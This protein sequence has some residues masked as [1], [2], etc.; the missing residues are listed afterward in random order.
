MSFRFLAGSDPTLRHNSDSLGYRMKPTD[1]AVIRF[2]QRASGSPKAVK[3]WFYPGDQYGLEFVYPKPTRDLIRGE[4]RSQ[5]PLSP[6]SP[7]AT[8]SGDPL[9]LSP[10]LSL[11]LILCQSMYADIF[12]TRLQRGNVSFWTE[13]LSQLGLAAAKAGCLVRQGNLWIRLQ[14]LYGTAA[15]SRSS[16]AVAVPATALVGERREVNLGGTSRCQCVVDA[17]SARSAW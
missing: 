11:F 7:A 14:R 15:S 12:R 9:L 6:A 2:G 17:D 4:P 1:E 13:L 8:P 3:A 16:A 5:R 10:L